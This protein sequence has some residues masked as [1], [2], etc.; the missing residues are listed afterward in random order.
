MVPLKYLG[1]FLRTLE[2]HLMNCKV[3]LNLTWSENC[4]MIYTDVNN[5]VPTFTITNQE[6]N[7]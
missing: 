1:N 6:T 7:L 4:V 3:E 5:Q 2:M